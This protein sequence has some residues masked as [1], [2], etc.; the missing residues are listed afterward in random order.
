MTVRLRSS[1]AQVPAYVPG[2]PPVARAGVTSYKMSSNENPYAP[3][4]AMVEAAQAAVATMNRYPDMSV[5]ELHAA[6]A[7]RLGVPAD[8]IASGTGSSGV[9]QQLVQATCNEGDEV[10]FAWRS[11]EAYPIVVAVNGAVARPVPLRADESH[12]LTAMA[13]AVTDRTRLV[14]VCQPNNPTGVAATRAELDAFI[15]A[16]PA[17]VLIVIDEAYVEFITDPDIADGL[18]LYRRHENVAVLRTFSKAYGLAGLRFGYAVAHAPVAAAL[19]ACAVPFG[20]SAPAQAAALAA[21]EC[22]PELLK[23]VQHIIDARTRVTAALRADGWTLPDS[24]SNFV[25]LRLGEHSPAFAALC[26]EHGLTVRPYGTE[27]VRIT[28]GDAAADDRFLAVAHEW[29]ASHA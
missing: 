27:G 5:R 19:R 13:A 10:V 8:H 16:V 15:A 14:L 26:E 18:E 7:D 4:P 25:W 23:R 6:L 28:V 21:L 12:D 2:K 20:V 9:L 3:M 24:Q 17:N 1:L 11:F 29:R 22:E